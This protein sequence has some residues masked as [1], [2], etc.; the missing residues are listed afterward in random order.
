MVCTAFSETFPWLSRNFFLGV[1]QRNRLRQVGSA[2][3]VSKLA[4]RCLQSQSTKPS[5]AVCFEQAPDCSVL[6]RRDSRYRQRGGE[7]ST[8][9]Q[10]SKRRLK[11]SFNSRSQ[12]RGRSFMRF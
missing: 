7:S 3:S 1:V 6:G 10:T 2:S 4:T 12:S 11:E 9:V 5:L 8:V